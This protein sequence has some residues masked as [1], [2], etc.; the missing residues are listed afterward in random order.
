MPDH[1][2]DFGGRNRIDVHDEAE[3]RYWCRQFGVRPKD[4]KRAVRQ[5]GHEP[6][7]VQR[8]FDLLELPNPGP[9]LVSAPGE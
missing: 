3:C 6:A 7:A 5:V 4:L 1:P 2:R 9:F 8:Y